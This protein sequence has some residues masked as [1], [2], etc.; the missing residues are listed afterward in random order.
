MVGQICK[1]CSKSYT[2]I[3]NISTVKFKSQKTP[4][5]GINLYSKSYMLISYRGIQLHQLQIF[6]FFT[7]TCLKSDG[8]ANNLAFTWE[9]SL[10]QKLFTYWSSVQI[11][12]LLVIVSTTTAMAI[13]I[14]V[15]I[16]QKETF[17][18]QYR[19][20]IYQLFLWRLNE[21]TLQL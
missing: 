12:T 5:V 10:T 14:T 20:R 18:Q 21:A 4:K 3:C 13:W 15:G 11:K 8:I 19:S 9:Y 16:S 7:L 6:I 1:N 17:W 2:F